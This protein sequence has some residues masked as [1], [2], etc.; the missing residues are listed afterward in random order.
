MQRIHLLLN[1]FIPMLNLCLVTVCGWGSNLTCV[2]VGGLKKKGSIKWSYLLRHA[3]KVLHKSTAQ[4][5]APHDSPRLL[6]NNALLIA[7]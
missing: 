6:L 4:H 3:D 2:R 1:Q 5:V 7:M